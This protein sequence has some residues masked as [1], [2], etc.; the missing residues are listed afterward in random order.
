MILPLLALVSSHLVCAIPWS[1]KVPRATDAEYARALVREAEAIVRAT[2]VRQLPRDPH[3]SWSPVQTRIE[4]RVEEVL[5]GGK[6][7][8]KLISPGEISEADDFN[9]L[10]VPYRGGRPDT[11]DG[12]CVAQH[13]RRG[14][15]FLLMLQ[16]KQGLLTPYWAAVAPVNEQLRSTRDPW[17]LWVRRQLARHRPGAEPP[18]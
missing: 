13:Y 6:I 14:G 4:F 12:D 8:R 18:A 5:K 2:A 17:L 1:P 3:A 10:T 11:R 9:D 16:R 7:P 15:Q